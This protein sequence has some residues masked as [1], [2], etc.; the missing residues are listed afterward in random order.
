MN[1]PRDDGTVTRTSLWEWVGLGVVGLA[2][3][4]LL[5]PICWVVWTVFQG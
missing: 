5:I 2:F 4:V 1:P 3:L